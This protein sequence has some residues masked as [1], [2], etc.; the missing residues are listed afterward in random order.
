MKIQLLTGILA[1]SGALSAHAQIYSS[2]SAPPVS[3]SFGAAA[4]NPAPSDANAAPNYYFLFDGYVTWDTGSVLTIG[5]QYQVD[6]SWSA[7]PGHNSTANFLLDINNNQPTW[8]FN[9]TIDQTKLA[10]GSLPATASQ[11]SDWKN[12]G[13][14]TATQTTAAFAW[15]FAAGSNGADT[16]GTMR[17][18]A[19]PEPSTYAFLLIGSLAGLLMLRQKRAGI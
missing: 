2:P 4:Y 3:S 19:V 17:L 1:L 14:F 16:T 10:N 11:W 9:F 7:N 18:T 15:D 6:T 12:L 5:Q 13:T 8:D